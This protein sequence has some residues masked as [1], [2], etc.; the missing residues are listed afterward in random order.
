MSG[1]PP[2]AA[3]AAG[4]GPPQA[5]PPASQGGGA[6]P[7]AGGVVPFPAMGAPGGGDD[8]Y[9]DEDEEDDLPPELAE[10]RD[11]PQFEQLAAMVVQNPQMLAQTNP[12]LVQ[13]IRQNPEAFMGMVQDAIGGEDEDE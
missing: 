3:G 10:L 12:E 9:D 2:G 6:P 13:A 1:I 7:A 5:A 11:S 8:D 4:R